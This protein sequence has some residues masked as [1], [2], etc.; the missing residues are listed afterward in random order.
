[1]PQGKNKS[2]A[3]KVHF[4][5]MLQ[6]VNLLYL[7]LKVI[8]LLENSYVGR[9]WTQFEAWLSMQTPSAEGLMPSSGPAD[10]S[11]YEIVPIYSTNTHLTDS[12]RETWGSKAPDEAR[13]VLSEP[14]VTVT[15]MGDKKTQLKKLLKFNDQVKQACADA[16]TREKAST[17]N[18]T[19]MGRVDE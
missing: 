17:D 18:V 12:L 3:E 14:S 2:P 7:G 8:I 19:P 13:D 16:Q 6:N 11:R 4:D 10:Q 1:M 15:N 9:F 5:F